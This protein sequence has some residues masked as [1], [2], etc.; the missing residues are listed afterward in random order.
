MPRGASQLL[1]TSLRGVVTN[2]QIALPMPVQPTEIQRKQSLG[3]AIALCVEASGKP[4]KAVLSEGH[5]DKGSSR[6][7]S[8]A[9]RASAGPSCRS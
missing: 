1:S 6:A 9:P 8:P 5:F 2:I 3:A 4:L 7:G